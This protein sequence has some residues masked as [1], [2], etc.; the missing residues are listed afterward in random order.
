METTKDHWRWVV[1]EKNDQHT[2]ETTVI[3][4]AP[5]GSYQE[6]E[7]SKKIQT[8]TEG[9]FSEDIGVGVMIYYWHVDR[10]LNLVISD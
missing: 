3:S 5:S 4:L 8:K 9:I 7:G 1:L 10:F 2:P 6:A